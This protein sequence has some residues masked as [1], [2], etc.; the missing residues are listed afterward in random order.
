VD[1]LDLHVKPALVEGCAETVSAIFALGQKD[2]EQVICGQ[3]GRLFQLWCA[4]ANQRQR[5]EER[6]SAILLA[7]RA[8]ADRAVVALDQLLTDRQAQA[9]AAIRA[10]GRSLRG[11]NLDEDRL[12][13]GEPHP[14]PGSADRK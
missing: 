14:W 9:Q 4:H 5:E 6:R 2:D 7:R 1:L 8:D 13:I 11:P 12:L 3:S 10:I